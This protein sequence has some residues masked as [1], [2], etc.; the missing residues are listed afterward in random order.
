MLPGRLMIAPWSEAFFK[1]QP[2][3]ISNSVKAFSL[4][5]NN[6]KVLNLL[7]FDGGYETGL[8]S[9]PELFS[10]APALNSL[11]RDSW[12]VAPLAVDPLNALAAGTLEEECF[13]LLRV[14]TCTPVRISGS[15]WWT[16][17]CT[18][19][20][21]EIRHFPGVMCDRTFPG[22]LG[23]RAAWRLMMLRS[24]NSCQS[25]A[26][27]QKAWSRRIYASTEGAWDFL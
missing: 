23:A 8:L 15:Q 16:N 1:Q 19:V 27:P 14:L 17:E 2:G 20:T 10:P 12:L 11:E 24:P 13:N 4:D 18:Q 6:S 3:L 5:R 9:T 7:F 21:T 26:S 25:N 22:T